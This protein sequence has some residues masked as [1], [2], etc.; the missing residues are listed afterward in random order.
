MLPGYIDDFRIKLCLTGRTTLTGNYQDNYDGHTPAEVYFNASQPMYP[1]ANSFFGFD[2]DTPFTYDGNHNLIVEVTWQGGYAAIG[3]WWGPAA[4]R[5]C[6]SY[7]L[8][9]NPVGGYPDAGMLTDN[10]HYM[11]VTVNNIGVAPTSL[12]RIKSLYR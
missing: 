8:N 12:G 9:G 4:G 5:H 7:I 1:P 10:L 11:R 2:L 3:T 6:Y